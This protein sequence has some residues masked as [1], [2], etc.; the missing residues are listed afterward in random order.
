MEKEN[1]MTDII[2]KA[3]IDYLMAYY[4]TSIT[5]RPVLLFLSKSNTSLVSISLSKGIFIRFS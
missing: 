5:T 1:I 3:L 4:N 2:D